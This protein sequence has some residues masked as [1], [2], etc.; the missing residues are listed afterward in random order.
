MVFNA[1]THCYIPE[2][3]I[4]GVN[5]NSTPMQENPIKN[6]FFIISWLDLSHNTQAHTFVYDHI[7]DV[8]LL[9]VEEDP[10]PMSL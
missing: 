4:M 10:R 9:L 3:H 6:F 1:N 7:G 5:V 2:L 8:L